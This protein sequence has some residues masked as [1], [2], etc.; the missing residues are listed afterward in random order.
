MSVYLEE[1]LSAWNQQERNKVNENWRRIMATFSKLQT[2]INILA[3]GEVDVLLERLNKAID[4]ANIAVQE[5]ID[6]NNTATQEAIQANNTALQTSLNTVSQTLIQVN[7]A[8]VNANTAT[9]GANTAKQGALD[10][11]AQAQTA[12]T[13]M[14]SLINNMGHRTTWN[15]ID[16]FYKN[17]MVVYNGSTFIA[18]QD[19]L[20]KIPP[21]LPTQS[22]A[23][24]SLFA[25]KGA[26]GDKGDKGDKGADGTGV[27]IIGSLPNEDDLPTTGNMGDAYLINGFLYVW[28]GLNWENVGKIQGPQGEPGPQ[29]EQGPPGETPDLTEINQKVEDLQTDV[30]EHLAEIATTE[31]LGHI[32]PDGTTIIVD[33][34]T[35]V[36]SAITGDKDIY[37]PAISTNGADY[38]VTIEGVTELIDGLT[39]TV[40]PNMT[41]TDWV[42]LNVNG[43]GKQ[44]IT[45]AS[46]GLIYVGLFQKDSPYTVRYNGKYFVMQTG[47]FGIVDSL[48]STAKHYAASANAVKTLNDKLT[49]SFW[50]D[51]PFQS[52]WSAP[53]GYLRYR[54][55]GNIVQ[56]VA[57]FVKATAGYSP[58][59]TQL[60][61]EVRPTESMVFDS[62]ASSSSTETTVQFKLLSNGYIAVFTVNN[63]NLTTY[64]NGMFFSVIYII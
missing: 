21:T 37:V 62:T 40:K 5:A 61:I 6:A 26:K 56:V 34:E 38:D 51:L 16:Q 41:N 57:A 20:G 28:N 12:I 7:Q 23:Y 24:W 59:M 39:F 10:A 14:Q 31:K 52:G 25:E 19:N 44:Y 9:D 17:N 60:P 3:G 15:A 43:L 64:N 4:D 22:N 11:T 53:N 45:H 55:M 63:T 36:A 47:Y 29:G 32:K 27:T 46:Q 30:T 48:T 49:P 50:V 2:Q 1:M 18:L 8:I 58:L 42:Y 54:R 33:E 35:G 13:T